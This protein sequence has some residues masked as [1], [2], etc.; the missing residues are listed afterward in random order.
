MN[1]R[2]KK[3]IEIRELPR[4]GKKTKA[5]IIYLRANMEEI[6]IIK[7][8]GGWRK[9]VLHHYQGGFYDWDYLR[10]MADFCEYATKEQLQ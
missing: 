3:Y 2:L 6:G 10:A 5:W 1:E 4:P 9:Y 7:W 8:H